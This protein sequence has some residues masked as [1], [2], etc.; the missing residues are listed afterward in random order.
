[1][2]ERPAKAYLPRRAQLRAPSAAAEAEAPAVVTRVQAVALLEMPAKAETQE[3]AVRV[4]QAATSAPAVTAVEAA[5]VAPAVQVAAP[6]A[7]TIKAPASETE[8]EMATAT[9]AAT[10]TETE[11]ET[12]TPSRNTP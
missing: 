11:T 7:R 2:A 6:A 9:E 3:A 4:I 12:E 8:M 1:M 10:E 5:T